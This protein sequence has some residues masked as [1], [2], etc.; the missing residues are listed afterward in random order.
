MCRHWEAYESQDSRRS[1]IKIQPE[2][3]LKRVEV[4]VHVSLYTAWLA[5]SISLV[6]LVYLDLESAS[7]REES[8]RRAG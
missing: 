8:Y 7:R 5:P 6:S 4:V 3:M 1:H 2:S